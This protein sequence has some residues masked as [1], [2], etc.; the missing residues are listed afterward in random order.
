MMD[1]TTV[2]PVKPLISNIRTEP[3]VNKTFAHLIKLETRLHSPDVRLDPRQL[4]ALLHP[5]FK[6]FGRSG[7][8]YDRASAIAALA[9]EEKHLVTLSRDFKAQRIDKR[10]VLLTYQSAHVNEAGGLERHTNRSSLWLD[11]GTGWQMIFHQGT[12][13]ASFAD[14]A[15]DSQFEPDT[16]QHQST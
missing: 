3:T 16:T 11:T 15:P 8:E 4:E 2:S 14:V 10:V 5:S 1:R 7:H 6:E 12:P 9:Q 13:T